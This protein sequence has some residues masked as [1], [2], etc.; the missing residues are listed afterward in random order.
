M[1]VMPLPTPTPQLLPLSSQLQSLPAELRF[2]ALSGRPEAECPDQLPPDILW[3]HIWST[4]IHPSLM[5]QLLDIYPTMIFM[6]VQ[7]DIYSRIVKNKEKLI[8]RRLMKYI[9]VLC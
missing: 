5:Q 8:A 7:K 4:E 2:L 9:T 3:T 1:W 6:Y